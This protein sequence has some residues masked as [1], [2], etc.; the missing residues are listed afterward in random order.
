MTNSKE[1]FNELVSRIT[2]PDEASEIQHIVSLLLSHVYQLTYAE[3]L[4]GKPIEVQDWSV[5]NSILDRINQCE[6]IQYIL[7]QAF[8][9][10]RTF[11]VNPA[12]LIP[13]PETELLVEA[14]CTAVRSNPVCKKILDIGT[15]SGCIAVT[16][17]LELS[18]TQ[19]Y[20]V[21]ISQQALDCAQKNA[22]DLN[23]VVT[24]KQL[25]ILTEDIPGTFD[26]IVSNPPYISH[27]EKS[28]MRK[29]VLDFE[30]HLA[31][32]APGE[33]ALLFYRII[34]EKAKR[35]LKA[36]GSLWFE[37]NE[38]FGSEIAHILKASGYNS[39]QLFKDLDQKDRMISARI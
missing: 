19:V 37:I 25:D 15:G 3:I 13:R 34:A 5:L 2:L 7:G 12:V 21:D 28:A 33:D 38:H 29:N 35:A 31:L 22:H 18:D 17:A 39:I 16:L 6:P 32:F 14:I 26:L 8:F 36:G 11:Q 24:F 1:L 20:A 4:A 30:P 10:G 23:A 27:Q 9:Y